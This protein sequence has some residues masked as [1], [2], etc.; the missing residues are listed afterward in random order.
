M[1]L[2]AQLV[3]ALVCGTRGRDFD[4]HLT[5]KKNFIK[6]IMINREVKYSY[7]DISIK[8]AIV[9]DIEHRGECNPYFNGTRLPLFTSPMDSVVSLENFGM[10]RENGITP[11]LP[12]TIDLNTRLNFDGNPYWA[13]F[14][15]QEFEDIFCDPNRNRESVMHIKALI[16]IANGHMKKVY[17]LVKTAKSLNPELVVM[18]GNVAN[19]ETYKIA[20]EAGVDYLRCSVGTGFACITSTQTSTHYPIASLIDEMAQIKKSIP[21]ART[22]IVADGGV[23][24]Y[25][26]VIKALALGADYVMIGSVFTKMLESAAKTYFTY[27]SAGNEWYKFKYNKDLHKYQDG[28]FY[29]YNPATSTWDEIILKKEF[30]GMASKKGQIA[31]NG[32]KTRT[33]EGISKTLPVEYTM[34]AWVE[35]FTDYLRSAMSYAGARTLEEFK[36]NTEVLVCSTGTI[37]S[38]NK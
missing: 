25:A 18:V 4:Y 30:Y 17:D 28:R 11:I 12:R 23:R 14:S 7:R 38:V 32:K 35:N 2:V 10:W 5:P 37:E 24:G 9:S 26:D 1:E 6:E 36:N 31:L 33:A 34:S 3:R 8:P 20:A 19:P 13:A 27:A 22:Q 21:E 29:D 15:L 16:D